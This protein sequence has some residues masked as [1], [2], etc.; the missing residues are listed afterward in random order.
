[1]KTWF[2]MGLMV[3]SGMVWSQEGV[4]PLVSGQKVQVKKLTRDINNVREALVTTGPSAFQMPD[5]VKASQ[6]RFEQFT[7][8][9]NR[10]PQ[11]ND[12]LVMA[13][14]EA[15]FK[16][17]AALKAEFKRAQEQQQVL[18]DVQARLKL[19]SQNFK[20]YPVPEP[21]Q[22]PFDEAAVAAW[23]KQASAA[24]T[25]GEHNLKEL[26]A[27]APLAY[28]P[29]NPGVPQ[30]GADYD[31][32]DLQ[33]M[34]QAAVNMQR[35]VQTNY[36]QMSEHL[37][38][39][40]QQKLDQ[41]NTRWQEDPRGDKKWVFLKADQV[42][43]A[44]QLFAE[45]KALAE[46]S[47]HLEQALNQDH[48]L[49]TQALQQINTAAEKFKANSQVALQSFRLPEAASDDDDMMAYAREILQR[50]R[51]EFGQHGPIVLTTSAIID[52]ESKS[53][54]IDIDKVDVAS[55][56]DI[57]LSG[58]ETTW[59]YRWQEFKFATPIK[60]ADGTW[61]IWW[62]TAKHYSSGSSITPIGEW[63]AGKSTKGNPILP[64]NF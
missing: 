44:E 18:G 37:K 30:N 63:V 52:R 10:Y 4:P 32:D 22:P 49:A 33:R 59:T 34:Q 21:M 26:N 20:Q 43:Q 25:V 45:S 31:S 5:Q 19:V 60:E 28:L 9:L 29:K 57:K 27:M 17:Q 14:R 42:K 47:I 51:Y 40:L 36:Q 61:Y 35:Q 7:A 38:S 13:A 3:L 2:V 46:S 56:G 62:I 53:S 48:S 11:L 15:Y 12:P 24:R 58:T 50:P 1:M 6:K 23:V 39:L 8:A 64:K 16:L 54:E 41:V 55:N